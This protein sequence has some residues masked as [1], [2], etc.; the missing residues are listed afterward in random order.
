[1]KTTT[2][3][4]TPTGEPTS[5]RPRGPL[6]GS[7]LFLGLGLGLAAAALAGCNGGDEDEA[8]S[9]P[10]DQEYFERHV[11]GPVLSTR[12][13]GCHNAEGL[14]KDSR[15]VLWGDDQE[16]YIEHNMEVT[17]PLARELVGDSSLF[18]LK[19][20]NEHADG[21]K[22]GEILTRDNPEFAALEQWV[23]RATGTYACDDEEDAL[24]CDA[25][26]AGAR[27]VRRL[28]HREYQ[29]SV[30][31]LFGAP[32]EI[33]VSFAP[34]NVVDGYSNNAAALKVSGL[35]AEQYRE[36]A[37]TMADVLVTDLNGYLPCDPVGD[38]EEACAADFID[39][40]GGRA[41][42]RPLTEP[43]RSRYLGLYSEVAEEDGF[44]EGIR[45]T[46][47]ALLQAP[48][49]LYRTELGQ[50]T[51][52]G[53]YALTPHELASEL[54]YLILGAAPDAPLR[55]LADDGSIS[56]PEVLEAEA[57]R[58][59]ADPRAEANVLRFADEWLG[60]DRLDL[61]TRD[62][63][64]YPELDD[65]IRAAMKGEA[66]R[67]VADVFAGGGSLSDLL[68]SSTSFMTPELASYYGQSASGDADPEGFIRVER[69]KG[70][71][72]GILTHGAT[73]TTHAL[74]TSSSPIHRGL[75]VRERFLCQHMP[76]PPPS[77]DASPPPVDPEL[78]TRERYAQHSEDATCA[79]C[80][81]LIDPLGFA[82]EGFDAVGRHRVLDGVHPI[83]DSGEILHTA[84]SDGTFT[85]V[86]E[87]AGLLAASEEVHAC[88]VDQWSRFV[89]GTA[90]PGDLACARDEL[91]DAFTESEG[92][93]DSLVLAL[94]RSPYF[95][96]RTGEIAE[97]PD[98]SGSSSDSDG[99]SDGS[100]DS[101]SD[102]S[103]D[104]SGGSDSDGTTGDSGDSGDS[105][106]D[107]PDAPEGI[108]V[109]INVDSMWPAGECDTVTITN[110][111][112]AAITWYALLDLPGALVNNW[113]SVATAEGDRTRFVGEAYNA[114]VEPQQSTSFG[115]CLE[116]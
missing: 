22:G 34:D 66:H 39:D 82:F 52:D 50:A 116:Y 4:C 97:L 76:P 13:A 109:M 70:A 63:M 23:A 14:A 62:P 86:A 55:A 8:T 110:T 26:G 41:F 87:L 81:Q 107:E 25:N 67:F 9:C 59:L 17:L 65:S 92:R 111:S 95:R 104:G 10:S 47:A 94:V 1:M 42:R 103:G 27:R 44:A 108:E 11:W 105:G 21:H 71:G 84:S 79:G 16:G 30:D 6:R 40:F 73:L 64:L 46:T 114:S 32:V 78:S 77:V 37:E 43:E 115:F 98:D 83:D 7:A 20:S 36:A 51:G 28:D 90:D 29:R 61:V 100:S 35:L 96:L 38:G 18:L 101:S 57:E 5:S 58:L 54:S 3:L 2:S 12:C 15:M 49:F 99:S 106:G 102:S 74:P 91:L 113:N 31:D 85:G 48:G 24:T 19:P 33:G 60:L 88:Y 75:L 56:D 69:S 89:L 45:W 72:A 53:N 112:G 68:T 80:H 93:L